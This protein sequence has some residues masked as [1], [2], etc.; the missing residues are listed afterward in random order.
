MTNLMSG[1]VPH[2]LPFSVAMVQLMVCI[3]MAYLSINLN[4]R[5]HQQG[6]YWPAIQ[7]N[8]EN[9]SLNLK[10][11]IQIMNEEFNSQFNESRLGLTNGLSVVMNSHTTLKV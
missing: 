3:A 10:T 11:K 6:K 1:K 7:F 2:S 9:V 5:I 8:M 4:R